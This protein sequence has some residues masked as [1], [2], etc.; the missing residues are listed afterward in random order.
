MASKVHEEPVSKL[1]RS[2]SMGVVMIT[3][4]TF[5]LFS[6]VLY[7]RAFNT[8]SDR[9]YEEVLSAIRHIAGGYKDPSSTPSISL[10]TQVTD[11]EFD[12]SISQISSMLVRAESFLSWVTDDARININL[13]PP[14]Y[15]RWD[16]IANA[17][18]HIVFKLVKYIRHHLS[19]D[20][21]KQKLLHLMNEGHQCSPLQAAQQEY[22]S[23]FI[24]MD[25]CS[26]V[27]W[28]KLAQLAWPQAKVF[29]DVGANKGYLG[30]LFL[31]LWGG[32]GLNAS[33]ADVYGH[34][35]KLGSWK[36]SRNPAGYCR[37]GHNFGIQS[38][39]PDNRYRDENTGKCMMIDLGVRVFSFDGSSY[40]TSALN[41]I[42]TN[43]LFP[44][45]LPDYETR[46]Q[47]WKYSNYAV[48]NQ[49]GTA[50]FTKQTKE[51]NAGYEGGGIRP[52]APDTETEE[53]PMTTVEAMI[54]HLGLSDLDLLK[55]DTEGNDNNVL[56]GAEIALR[57][58]IGMFTFEGGLGITFSKEMVE[59]FNGWGY[60]CYSTSRAGLF[61]W[62]GS[63]MKEKY[64]GGFKAKDKGNIF[65]VS[66]RKA[67][68]AAL[69][70]EILSFP[71]MIDFQLKNDALNL[72][73]GDQKLAHFMFN[74]TKPKGMDIEIEFG[75]D[76][77]S[78]L[79]TSLYVNI[80]G[81]CKPW[82]ACAKE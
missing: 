45:D 41:G 9:Q 39:C 7:K 42:I 29:F 66:R 24:K 16:L 74:Q 11:K 38:Y 34:A 15:S 59:T 46:R 64:L 18:V 27:E 73:K 57:N 79:L 22:I 32:G 70:F 76:I 10:S 63:C 51:K 72:S 21:G 6:L 65:C 8:D 75:N 56:D 30:S 50:K 68:M 14:S 3:L 1:R 80:Y 40:L 13:K 61:K 2:G 52:G 25:I 28:Y 67:P 48:S 31:T 44:T 4:T 82:P 81:F 55:I 36:G 23:N 35:T 54:K 78:S 17:D 43:Q 60:N 20:E 5:L 33:P 62:N 12:R 47:M 37:D 19:S 53:V 26:E 58:Q 69:A 71:L 77:D 49:I